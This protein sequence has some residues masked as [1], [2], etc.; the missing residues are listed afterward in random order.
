MP[1]NTLQR[2]RYT[3]YLLDQNVSVF[4]LQNCNVIGCK[5][6]MQAERDLIDSNVDF[7]AKG[8]PRLIFQCDPDHFVEL[9]DHEKGNIQ[10][11]SVKTE[12]LQ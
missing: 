7:L 9:V 12:V 3:K 4:A 2:A 5:T 10:D 1:L 8:L 11:I 6:I